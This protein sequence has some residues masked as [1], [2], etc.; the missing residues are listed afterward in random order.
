MQ[1]LCDT[2]VHHDNGSE[3]VSRAEEFC[4]QVWLY[5]CCIAEWLDLCCCLLCWSAE[6][7]T[8]LNGNSCRVF[9]W[10]VSAHWNLQLSLIHREIPPPPKYSPYNKRSQASLRYC[11]CICVTGSPLDFDTCGC[12]GE[13]ALHSDFCLNQVTQKQHQYCIYKLFYFLHLLSSRCM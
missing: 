12:E 11:L 6:H 7:V 9:F 5:S 8:I 3:T 10:F 2:F 1:I 4:S 13:F